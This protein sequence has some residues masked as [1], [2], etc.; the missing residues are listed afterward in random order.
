MPETTTTN[1]TATRTLAANL[2][3]VSTTI[4]LPTSGVAGTT[5]SATVTF[6]NVGAATTTFTAT[7]TING[8]SQ[9]TTTV[10]AGG[11]GTVT[12]PIVVT[13]TNAGAT[14]TAGVGTTSVPE[15][16]TTNNT[17]TRILSNG[18]VDLI[19]S[20]SASAAN[21]NA[22]VVFTYNVVVSNAG[23]GTASNVVVTDALP[24]GIRL[25]STTSSAGLLLTTS[26]NALTGT[27]A[28]LAA[29]ASATITLV[30]QADATVNGSIVNVASV[31]T[32][33]VD[34]NVAN[35]R[36]TATVVVIEQA[37]VQ[38]VKS[39]SVVN[40]NAGGTFSYSIVVFNA[41]PSAA[42]NLSV[43]D[44]LPAGI[45]LLN[46]TV[47]TGGLVLN[48]T[49]NALT[50]TV[51]SLAANARAN[52]VLVVQAAADAS[53]PIGNVAAVESS[54]P[55]PT[56]SNNRSTATVTVTPMADLQIVK[57]ASVASAN[58]DSTFS[59][60]IVVFNA[61]PG[62]ASNVA[63]VDFLPAG[64]SLINAVS[65]GGWA[66]NTTTSALTATVVSLPAN[67]TASISLTVQAAASSSG[68]VTNVAT[69]TS[70][71]AD[72]TPTNN[73][74]TATM[75]VTK[76]VDISVTISVPSAATPGSLITAAV[77]VT[78]N[79]PST[80]DAVSA[81]VT[82]PN[83]S[84]VSV[85]LSTTSLA[86][87]ETTSGV[88]T[89]KVP[90]SQGTTMTWS[91]VVATT[92][93]ETETRN[94]VATAT[95]AIIKVFS[96]SISGRVWLDGDSD[97]LYTAGKDVDLSGWT[98]ELLQGGNVVATATTGVNGTYTIPNQLPGS[99]YSIRF[100]NPFGNIVTAT[101]LNQ[102]TLADSG[103]P[104]RASTGKTNNQLTGTFVVSGAID[105]VTLYIGDNV[106]EQNLPIDPAGVVYDSVSRSIL[107]NAS[108]TLVFEG[109]GF[110]PALHLLPLFPGDIPT[111]VQ[112]GIYQFILTPDAPRGVYKLVVTPPPGYA[113][114]PG[115]LGGVSAPGVAPGTPGIGA[116]GIYTP[117]TSV[118][119]VNVQPQVGAP[120]ASIAGAS[121]VNTNGTQ[122]FL[123]FNLF[124]GVAN[125][126][127]NHIPLDP[128][129][130]GALLVS[131]V[132]DKSVAEI[133]DSVKY[134][135]RI[136]NTTNAG[137]PAVRLEDLLPAGFRYIL[138]TARLNT[139]V[140]ADPAGGVG[141][142]LSF[143][144]GSAGAI[145]ANT[146]WELSYFVRLGV[147]SQQGDGIN[148]ATAVFQG[149][150]G[151]VRSNT[152]QF[153]VRVQGG[154]FSNEG[155]IA[156]KVYVD[157]DGNHIQNN[158]SGSRELGIPGVRL[159][160]LDGTQ[161]TTDS[162]GKYSICGVRPQT[163]V[164]KVDRTTL[165]KGSRLMPSSNRNAGVGDTIFVDLKGGELARADFI[166]GSCAPEVLDQVKARRAQGGL[167]GPE[168]EAQPDLKI[169]NRPLQVEQQIL[170]SL[171]LE[172]PAPANA[173]GKAP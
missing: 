48:T 62:T 7:I 80:A 110:D 9:V 123:R 81:V 11:G 86:K 37:D 56:P 166:E 88:V 85:G 87:G 84:T 32:T 126:F 94:N 14:V 19:I 157:C 131:K 164:I 27:V 129:T 117:P 18:G 169:D 29:N 112:P 42:G 51:G 90:G 149:V 127:H 155:C 25:L 65:T 100:R 132:G 33:S 2:S 12:V 70:T 82:L 79:G 138:G 40:V 78:N 54:T 4:A 45:R 150:S 118:A 119:F 95:T 97:K 137:I 34:L 116:G 74:S 148:R 134:I 36:S 77:V 161:I 121:A 23:P 171:R 102:S 128:L 151:P 72:A 49:T 73:T 13:V 35:N 96:A 8:V 55:D 99:G 120:A 130:S 69:I 43:V 101:P 142:A 44:A 66:L 105:N 41:G 22:N 104:E 153:R 172:S 71:T 115:I 135:I 59:Y 173:G 10:V 147:G 17:A 75:I 113:E 5:V 168:K 114:G 108:V 109:V 103:M 159:I 139:D 107:F 67:A 91:V 68:V 167:L 50:A 3:D 125:I 89:Y 98:V 144:I 111:G 64:I 170:P 145:P 160:M 140:L 165:P 47:T 61:G 21:I 93:P 124:P 143:N 57:S 83:G 163:H 28:A 24:P 146:T 133:G 30:V 156:G 46:A 58:A 152:A 158:E 16:T 15:T 52:I 76:L 141:R 63:V 154:V 122:Y 26:T 39:A 20:K 92:T 106:A 6:T 1:N 60:S 136:R 38:I 31:T 53:G 162:E